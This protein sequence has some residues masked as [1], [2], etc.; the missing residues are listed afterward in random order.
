MLKHSRAF[1]LWFITVAFFA[2]QFVLRNSP[3]LMFDELIAKFSIS[4]SEFAMFS[5]V[6]YLVYA[7][8][9]IPAGVILDR[10]NIRYSIPILI[11]TFIF[12]AFLFIATDNFYIAILGRML[13]GVGATAGFL[14]AAKVVSLM[15]PKSYYSFMISL[16]F[17]TGFLGAIYGGKP[18]R[19]LI[20][21]NGSN[22]TFMHFIYIGALIALLAFIFLSSSR[23]N[24]EKQEFTKQDFISHLTNKNILMT[25]IFGGFMMGSTEGFADAWG[26]KFIAT[27]YALSMADSSFVVSMVY[28]GLCFGGPVLV[29]LSEKFFDHYNTTIFSGIIM[30]ILFILLYLDISFTYAELLAITIIMGIFTGSQV[31]I[32]SLT[33]SFCS[34]RFAGIT[35]AITNSIVM[36]FGFIIHQMIGLIIDLGQGSQ[37]DNI[38]SN[39]SFNIAMLAIAVFM[40]IGSAGIFFRK[41]KN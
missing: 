38:I 3:G 12:G 34:D 31:L 32:F 15:F 39:Q 18:M 29:W 19:L 41:L 9:Q 35:S 1:F 37:P 23:Q 26:I 30:G 10:F 27:K 13:M 6:F 21:A 36:S 2:Y 28:L 17:T 33:N 11:T 20:E 14:G 4:A 25:A 8:M 40:F 5:S 16:T 22:A 7:F 24:K